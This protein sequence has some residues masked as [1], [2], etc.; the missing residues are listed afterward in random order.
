MSCKFEDSLSKDFI[1]YLPSSNR[2]CIFIK[3]FYFYFWIINRSEKIEFYN[4]VTYKF[5]DERYEQ[6]YWYYE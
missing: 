1:S 5:C 6:R 4:I 3:F 2:H